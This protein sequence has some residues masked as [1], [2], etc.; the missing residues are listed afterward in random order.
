[1]GQTDNLERVDQQPRPKAVRHPKNTAEP[2]SANPHT[3]EYA[4]PT[5]E[6]HILLT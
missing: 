4:A 1:M 6:A 5:S 3:P 2:R